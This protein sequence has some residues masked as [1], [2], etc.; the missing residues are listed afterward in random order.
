MKNQ[1]KRIETITLPD[2][3]EAIVIGGFQKFKQ[4]AIVELSVI[5]RL[6]EQLQKA[7]LSEIR[8]NFKYQLGKV[9]SM[10]EYLN[11]I[12]SE[13]RFHASVNEIEQIKL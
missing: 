7:P 4:P 5:K 2:H 6:A 13:L 9:E 10:T 1:E 12:E 3:S 8:D 11:C